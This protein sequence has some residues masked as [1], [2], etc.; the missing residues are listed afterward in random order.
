MKILMPDAT[1]LI[2]TL[3]RAVLLDRTLTS[4]AAMHVPRLRWE[5]LVV[6]NGSTDGT[7]AL[8]EGRQRSFPVPLRYVFERMPGR[9]A[10]MNTGL[11]AS[12]AP[13][14][15]FTDDDVEVSAGWL[16]A[17]CEPMRQDAAI[18]YTGGPVEPIWEA[19]C[20]AWFPQTG[21]T[22]WGTLAI[23]DYGA[24]PFVFEERQRVPLGVNFALRRRLVDDIGAFEPSLGRSSGRVLL[25]QEVPELL[26]RAREAGA[27][28]MYVPAM[29][30]RH[31]VPARRLRASYCRRWWYGKGVSRAR[32]H[33][34]HPVTELGLD[35]RSV[36][37]IAGVPRFLFGDAAREAMRWIAAAATG[38][39][40]ARIAAETQ[41]CY[42]AGL[43]R[44]T[45]RLTA[46]RARRMPGRMPSRKPVVREP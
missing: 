20:P 40:G 43:I 10:A 34:R 38:R 12:D 13:F 2:C 4:L 14:V 1:V 22:L 37:T 9:S 3:N 36:P 44:E 42:L 15:V 16:E 27:H 25:G 6:D 30:V 33:A 8:V 39:T 11:A 24:E 31:H 32:L 41:L 7:R 23:L 45:L 18:A 21:R 35:L 28:G 46:P 19:P 29:R 17:A 5:V 26:C